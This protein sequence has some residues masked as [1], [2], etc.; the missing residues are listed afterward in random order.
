MIAGA[1]IPIITYLPTKNIFEEKIGLVYE[2]SAYEF[3]T[4][5]KINQERKA[6]H[7]PP[8]MSGTWKCPEKGRRTE[9]AIC[10]R[11]IHSE[12]YKEFYDALDKI[13]PFSERE[14][15]EVRE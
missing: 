8:L 11:N 10:H 1:G 15:L 5:E 7:K 2:L 4:I 13:K 14:I 12:E 9:R 6:Q 3:I